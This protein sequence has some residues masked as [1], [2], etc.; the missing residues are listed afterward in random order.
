MLE[1]AVGCLCNAN[2]R[3]APVQLAVPLQGAGKQGSK[4]TSCARVLRCIA[5]HAL[6]R[7]APGAT[8]TAAH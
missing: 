4:A 7:Q 5:V 1:E 3:G 6:I 8:L 2:A